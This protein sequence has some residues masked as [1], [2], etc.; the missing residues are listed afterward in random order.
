MQALLR[1]N[2]YV[3]TLHGHEEMEADGLT[4]YDVEHVIMTGRI[5]ERRR[6]RRRRGWKYLV[7]GETMDGDAARVV[8]K[9]GPTGKL[10]VVT[11]CVL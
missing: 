5:V 4:V 2:D 11:V 9:V 6:D 7:E 3:V 10:V 1:A 8:S